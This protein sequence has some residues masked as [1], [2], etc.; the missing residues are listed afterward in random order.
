MDFLMAFLNWRAVFF[1]SARDK[2]HWDLHEEDFCATICLGMIPPDWRHQWLFFIYHVFGFLLEKDLLSLTST[3]ELTYA[4]KPSTNDKGEAEVIDSHDALLRY[5]KNAM[6]GRCFGV[7][8]KD[9]MGLGSGCLDVDDAVVVPLGCNT[10]ILLRKEGIDWETKGEAKGQY[11]FVGDVYIHGYMEG[12]AI[13]EMNEKKLRL[14]E[15]V[16]H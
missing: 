7:T 3:L 4:V 11:R 14:E 2:Y 16:I 6:F 10:P 15:F 8:D 13:E 5:F 9:L 1:G 12:R